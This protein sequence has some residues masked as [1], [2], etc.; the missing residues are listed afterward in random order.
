MTLRSDP[1]ISIQFSKKGKDMSE[2]YGY[3]A[4]ALIG[5]TPREFVQS[6][7]PTGLSMY[8][9]TEAGI[10]SNIIVPSKVCAP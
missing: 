6:K 1:L 3:L 2:K 10:N 9:C 5:Q 8:K 4:R 7:S